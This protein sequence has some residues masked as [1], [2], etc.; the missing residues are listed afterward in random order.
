MPNH[1]VALELLRRTGPLAVTSANRSDEP[2]AEDRDTLV[3]I[4]GDRVAV[5]VTTGAPVGGLAST[6]VDL[7]GPEPRILR[8][9][10]IDDARILDLVG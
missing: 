7:T 1:A 3:A 6:V 8:R 10:D 2:P 9:G 5:Y 4:F